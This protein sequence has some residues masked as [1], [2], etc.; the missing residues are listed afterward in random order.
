MNRA[1]R[2]FQVET[3]ESTLR[4]RHSNAE[5][6]T[7]TA[8]GGLVSWRVDADGHVFPAHGGMTEEQYPHI[9]VD[10]GGVGWTV[11]E[12]DTPQSW[13]KGHRCL[14]L[15]SRECVRRVWRYPNNWR[16]LDTDTLLRLD[17]AD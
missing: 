15:N 11:R 8:V 17:I 16:H 12:I 5:A 6:F 13:A 1:A 2:S 4:L 9:V 10:R 3:E 7:S 14:V